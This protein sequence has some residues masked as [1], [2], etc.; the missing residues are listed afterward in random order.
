MN[1]L[2]CWRE[3]QKTSE[4]FYSRHAR[5]YAEVSHGFI[6]SIYNNVSHPG[7]T[8]DLDL[9]GRMKELTPEGARGLDVGCG[10]T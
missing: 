9:I 3:M 7:L 8:G 5:R 2:P 4:E 6:Q 10:A 1:F